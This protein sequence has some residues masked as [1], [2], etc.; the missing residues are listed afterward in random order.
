MLLTSRL[1]NDILPINIGVGSDISIKSLAEK[2][3]KIVG[4]SGTIVW[5]K[6]KPDGQFRKYYDMGLFKKELGYI[7]NTSLEDGLKKTILW[8]LTHKSVADRRGKE[9]HG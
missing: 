1:T 9:L 7:P 3:S 6:S 2:I 5:D 8:Y 4:Y